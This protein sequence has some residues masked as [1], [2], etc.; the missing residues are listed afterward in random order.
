[1]ETP[2]SKSRTDKVIQVIGGACA[3]LVLGFFVGALLNEIIPKPYERTVQL[4]Q[5]YVLVGSSVGLLTCVIIAY[6]FNAGLPRR[7]TNWF[8]CLASGTVIGMLLTVYVTEVACYQLNKQYPPHPKENRANSE[9]YFALKLGATA[10]VFSGAAVGIAIPYSR[11]RRVVGGVILTV[12]ILVAINVW[13][14]EIS[15]LESRVSQR[16]W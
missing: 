16:N 12:T 13:N 5:K 14:D 6:W 10:G 11:Q 3:G 15:D 2:A 9:R 4:N 8:V 7:V 1:M